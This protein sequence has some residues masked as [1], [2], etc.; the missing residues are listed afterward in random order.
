MKLLK[1]IFDQ[2]LTYKKHVAKVLKRGVKAAL[3]LKMFRNL[4]PK[5]ARRLFRSMV[6]LVMD[7]ASLI[8]SSKLVKLILKKVD[9][10]QII[11]AQAITGEFYTIVLPIAKAKAGL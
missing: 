5:S 6:A 2:K 1:V 11:E 3:S 8:W 9:Q 10:I 7:Y 4:R